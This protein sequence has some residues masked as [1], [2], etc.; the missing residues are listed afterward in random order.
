MHSSPS[1]VHRIEI[2]YSIQ[3]ILKSQSQLFDN[4][5]IK[6]DSCIN[7]YSLLSSSCFE[8]DSIKKSI[9]EAKKRGITVRYITEITKDNIQS[10]KELYKI[11]DGLRHLDRLKSNFMLSESEYISLLGSSSLNEKRDKKIISK[12]IYSN[13]KSFIEEQ[14]L[15]F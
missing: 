6:I 5:K 9:M 3:E 11:I 7:Y 1:N 2:V 13:I 12:V 8:L 10:C 15:L 4:S 14:Q